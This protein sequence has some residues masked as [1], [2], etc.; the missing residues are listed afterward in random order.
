MRIV[1]QAAAPLCYTGAIEYTTDN[2][3]DVRAEEDFVTG[4]GVKR[5]IRW[6]PPASAVRESLE[7]LG[8]FFCE[9][10]WL[11]LRTTLLRRTF[12]LFPTTLATR[13]SCG[14]GGSA[15]HLTGR[16]RP[17]TFRSRRLGLIGAQQAVF[18]RRAIKAAD[19]QVHLFRVGCVDECESLGLLRL[20]I[21]DYFDIVVYEV[22]CVKPGLDVV[23]RNP[24]RQVS[25]EYCEAHS[26][27]IVNSV[28]GDFAELL[29][30]CDP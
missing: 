4:G 20:G 23:L 5:K 7:S 1:T 11:P 6:N 30:G 12:V 8:E 28:V 10:A 9:G 29:R 2:R 25:E 18:Q 16:T 15:I 24:D 21:A 22:F 17:G 13:R 26:R 19:D 14:G 27:S 3:D